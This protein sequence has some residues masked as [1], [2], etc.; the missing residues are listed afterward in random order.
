MLAQ[1]RRLPESVL[2]DRDGYTDLA[3]GLASRWSLRTKLAKSHQG[4]LTTTLCR[5]VLLC[6]STY[7][8]HQLLGDLVTSSQNTG[9][10]MHIVELK[11]IFPVRWDM[12]CFDFVVIQVAV[13]LTP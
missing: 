2:V 8:M 9:E 11:F 7:T 1:W 3:P 5:S 12:R 10:Y 13:W 4:M 6:E